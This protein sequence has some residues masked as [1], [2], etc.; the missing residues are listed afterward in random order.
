MKRH[1][2]FQQVDVFTNTPYKGNPVAVILDGDDLS[3]EEMQQIASWTNLSE[4]TFVC[5]PTDPTADYRLRIFTP[6]NELPFAGHPTLGSAYA[7]I[8]HGI[9]PNKTGCLVQESEIGLVTI[10]IEENKIFFTLP[11]SQLSMVEPSK[12]AEV[13]SALGIPSTSVKAGMIID[14]GAVWLTLYLTDGEE[15]KSLT[16][17]MNKLSSSTP[18]G[19]TGVTV[20]GKSA[21]DSEVQ[22][23]VRSF[24][25]NEGVAE[26]PVC[27]SGNGCV[28]TMVK[29]LQLI[30]DSNYVASQGVCVGRDGR[31]E[32]RFNDDG[33]ILLGGN[34]VTCIEGDITI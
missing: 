2:P 33:K 9:E 7:L 10:F 21:L 11:D 20:F 26:D 1:V 3:T 22:F 13:A 8:K 31:I 23:E 14:V 29:Q 30:P 15:V 25:P 18:V 16:P 24:A 32:V 34:A 17:N 4:T 6:K 28:A 19:V 5:T 27:G 12:L